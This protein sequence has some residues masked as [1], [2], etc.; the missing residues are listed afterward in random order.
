MKNDNISLLKKLEKYNKNFVNV[1]NLIKQ[2]NVFC[3][4]KEYK[5][6]LKKYTELEKIV[7]LYKEYKKQLSLLKEAVFFIDN[8]LDIEMKELAFSEKCKINNTLK[9]IKGKI[10]D[11]ITLEKQKNN[12]ENKE[13][14]RNAILEIR[15]GTGGDEACIF[16]EDILRMYT[17]YFKKSGWN[18][19]ILH[20]QKGKIKGYK[21]I[22]LEVNDKNKLN[23]VYGCLK[24][25]SGVHRV[26]RIPKTESQGRIHTS[27]ITVAVLPQVNDV[28][29][30]INSSD[31]KKET[32]RSSGA[33]G[34]HVNKTESAIRLTHNPS[35]ITVVCQQE[36]SQHKNFEKAIS[37]LK[38]KLFK[39]EIDK[40]L[41]N[42]ALTRKN[43]ISTGDR[44]MKIR[45]YNYPNNKVIDHRIHKTIH[46]LVEFMN[47][48]I[49]EMIISLKL[50][51]TNN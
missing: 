36:R 4:N 47:G 12:V 23:E 43:L 32:F 30:K 26:Q 42:R 35:N 9:I 41:K 25:E 34:Q 13:D 40:K 37:I 16:V 21:E 7:V 46:N 14:Y 6:L 24:F 27:A 49:K 44:S 39:I 17:M 29:I 19:S 31:I 10:Y 18:Y 51:Q 38:S 48:N 2:K 45:T 8:E 5:I 22:V 3:N 20:F 50:Y 33:G 28:E 11:F 1:Y 15:S